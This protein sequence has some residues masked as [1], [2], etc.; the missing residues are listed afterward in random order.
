MPYTTFFGDTYKYFKTQYPELNKLPQTE[1]QGIIHEFKK[2]PY[3]DTFE[4]AVNRTKQY[5]KSHMPTWQKQYINTQPIK[6]KERR[7]IHN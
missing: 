5:I 3:G 6:E 4:K 7:R 2:S 1:I